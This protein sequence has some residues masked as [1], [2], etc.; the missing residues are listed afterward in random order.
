MAMIYIIIFTPLFILLAATAYF[1]RKMSLLVVTQHPHIIS[2]Q[3]NNQ[4]L[5]APSAWF[6][7][8][9]YLDRKDNIRQ[10]I[11]KICDDES[12][13]NELN[14]SKMYY[15]CNTR[16][17]L[18]RALVAYFGIAIMLTIFYWFYLMLS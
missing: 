8:I 11:S 16:Q 6:D 17:K 1:S 3:G 10:G 2:N 18:M 9:K 15:I 14:D 12:T 7:P 4:T 13:L 5:R